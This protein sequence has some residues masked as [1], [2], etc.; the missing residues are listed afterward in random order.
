MLNLLK[1][2]FKSNNRPIQFI[3]PAGY[4]P[5][6]QTKL[7]A[8]YD[9]KAKKNYKLVKGEKTLIGTNVS[10]KSCSK[11]YFLELHPRSSF[12]AVVGCEGIGIIDSDYRKEIMMIVIPN[13]D[14]IVNRGERIAQLIPKKVLRVTNCDIKSEFRTGGIG[15]TK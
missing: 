5:Q 3:A 10:I 12:R 13:K 1:S 7:S 14:Y 8:G 15:S 6:A 4:M 2:I 11:D 9:V